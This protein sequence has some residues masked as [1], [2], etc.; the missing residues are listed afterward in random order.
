MDDWQSFWRR[1]STTREDHDCE[2]VFLERISILRRGTPGWYAAY[3]IGWLAILAL[4]LAYLGLM[5]L[6]AGSSDTTTLG[7]L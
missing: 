7:R 3:R 4:P 5:W 6:E 1:T 2:V